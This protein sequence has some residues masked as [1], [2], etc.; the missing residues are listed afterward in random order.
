MNAIHFN[1]IANSNELPDFAKIII[2][3][4]GIYLWI[5]Y[6]PKLYKK[7]VSKAVDDVTN[8]VKTASIKT[9]ALNIHKLLKELIF[10]IIETQNNFLET[11]VRDDR[12]DEKI[13]KLQKDL[14]FELNGP[15]PIH[16]VKEYIF[17]PM[18]DFHNAHESV[19]VSVNHVLDSYTKKIDTQA[20]EKRIDMFGELSEE[21]LSLLRKPN[22]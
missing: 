20:E 12:A 6:V 22:L 16:Y 4:G 2:I 9:S 15:I 11:K 5:K 18:L 13:H 17:N 14:L 3:L 7:P 1:V 10:S 19:R 8:T 21:I